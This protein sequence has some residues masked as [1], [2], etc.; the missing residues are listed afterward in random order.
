MPCLLISYTNNTFSTDYVPTVLGN[1]SAD[2]LVNRQFLI[3]ASRTLLL[4]VHALSEFEGSC[5][6]RFSW[7]PLM[8]QLRWFLNLHNQEAKEKTFHLQCSSIKL[9]T[10][11][12]YVDY[13]Y[14]SVYF[15]DCLIV[16][17]A[18]H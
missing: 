11:P 7:L 9:L 12:V 13:L 14:H 1:F 6:L 5:G 3:R 4:N 15:N 10:D 8:L 17:I 18:D 16:S 2:V